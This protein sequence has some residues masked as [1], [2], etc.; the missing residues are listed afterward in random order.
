MEGYRI[1]NCTLVCQDSDVGG[2]VVQG[3]AKHVF[4]WSLENDEICN[5]ENHSFPKLPPTVLRRHTCRYSS[6]HTLNERLAQKV[7]RTMLPETHITFCQDSGKRL[8]VEGVVSWCCFML[9]HL[10]FGSPAYK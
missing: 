1:E 6:R 9:C 7:E 2:V 8:Y 3:E 10:R 5:F 4:L